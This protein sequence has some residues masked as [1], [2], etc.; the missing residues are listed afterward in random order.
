M[1]TSA[2]GKAEQIR[3]ILLMPIECTTQKSKNIFVYQNRIFS[4]QLYVG[5]YDPDMSDFAVGFYEILYKNILVDNSNSEIKILDSRG[6]L[7]DDDFAGDT[8]NSFNIIANRIPGAGKSKK[9]RTSSEEW[10]E[11]LRE[12][13]E[14]Y[15]CL[16]NFW[17]L[18]KDLGRT[19]NPLS[20]LKKAYDYMDRF[21]KICKKFYDMDT[22]KEY[23]AYESYFSKFSDCKSD[24]F[25]VFTKVHLIGGYVN[26]NSDIMPY[27]DSRKYTGKTVV[28]SMMRQIKKRAKDIS[29]SQI[30]EELW[31]YFIDLKIV[32]V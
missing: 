19:G 15:H 22:P 4:S 10:P 14:H 30:A 18:P 21:L 8:M 23:K 28:D 9:K 32:K 5:D 27:S 26:E 31:N 24:Y 3:A 2:K 16:A 7:T 20:K 6:H 12:Y 25:D 29:E 11:Y 17:L 1:D 13:K